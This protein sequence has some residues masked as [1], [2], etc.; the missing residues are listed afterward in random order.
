M[1]VAFD[2]FPAASIASTTAIENKFKKG[3]KST[4]YVPMRI[5]LLGQYL[6]AK[7]PVNNVAVTGMTSADD[8]AA[9]AGYGS[10][11]HVL[12]KKLFGAMGS[13]PALVDWFPIAD[14]TTAQ[15]YTITFVG[16]ASTSG[17]W[18]V[19]I[20]GKRYELPVAT[21]DAIATQA[22]NLAA[23]I[24]A[25]LDCPFTAVPTAGAVALTAKWKGLSSAGLT[26]TKNY[27]AADVNLIPGTT[28]MTIVNTT[29]GA[30]DPVL[31][32]A[33]GNFANV[34]YTMM[35]SGLNDA[36]AAAA[37][38]AAWTAR[39][40]PTVKKPV[41]GVMGYTD[42][43]ANF[44]TALAS[45]NNPGSVYFPVEGSPNWHGE[46]AAELVGMMA[47]SANADPARPF[48]NLIFPTILPSVPM[49]SGW[50]YAQAQ[51]VE[52][53]GGSAFHVTASGQVKT[54]DV[55]TTYKTNAGGAVDI[56]WRYACTITNTQQKEYDLD[57]MLASSPFDR[58]LIVDD[59]SLSSKE[60]ALSPKKVAAFFL[61]KFEQWNIQA[62]SFNLDLMR[63]SLTTEIDSGN[64]G[65]IN[66][67]F[68]DY[69]TSGLRI[70]A[71]KRNWS[72]A[73]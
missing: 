68:T 2:F 14:G 44:L 3:G 51:A 50:T 20:N 48:K 41:F 1:A 57:Q 40:D 16:V 62:W 52:L 22:T 35:L 71:V 34:N 69:V 28:T 66:V 73:A 72:F 59:T 56:S 36:T 6:A 30:T 29:A 55:L 43:R 31:T 49:G 37:Y 32:T 23:L 18:R 13:V 63:A 46:I 65:R 15:V 64:P 47:V 42:T 11:A 45:R 10:Q 4:S 25:D 58:A 67:E 26:V 39:I 33:I 7:S 61:D 70:V 17:V 5:A 53:A 8:V 38:E 27:Y 9:L 54:W 12:A 24:T 19:Y 60:Y 21:S